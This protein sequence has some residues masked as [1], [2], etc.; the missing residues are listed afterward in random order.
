MTRSQVRALLVEVLVE[1]QDAVTDTP[2][3]IDDD[4]RPIGDLPQFDS[5]LAED[6]TVTILERLNLDV[7]DDPNPFI[8][9]TG[10]P[11]RFG[12]VVSRVC[13]LVGATEDA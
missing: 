7:T 5:W 1:V 10:G 6:T 11:A 13:E 8:R 4:T 3:V 12:E 9:A 2:V